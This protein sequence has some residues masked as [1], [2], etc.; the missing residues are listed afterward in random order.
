M[1]VISVQ[2]LSLA[3]VAHPVYARALPGMLP[4]THQAEVYD[5]WQ[6]HQALLLVAP[7]GGGKTQA[8]AFPIL[9]H[10]E[11]AIFVYPTNALAEDQERSICRLLERLEMPYYQLAAGEPWDANAYRRTRAVLVRV[12]G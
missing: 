1:S 10:S 6:H 11:S 5:A 8:A 2:P 4:Y 9:D 12:E 3:Q 7:T